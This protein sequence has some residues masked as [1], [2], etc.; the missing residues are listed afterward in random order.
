[1]LCTGT[2]CRGR[3]NVEIVLL[4]LGEAVKAAERIALNASGERPR[5]QLI[6]NIMSEADRPRTCDQIPKVRNV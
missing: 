2:S 6:G 5:R 3:F 4:I 1:M